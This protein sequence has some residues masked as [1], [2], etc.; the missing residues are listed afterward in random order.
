VAERSKYQQKI[1]K[2]YYNNVEAISL[3][4]A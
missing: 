2:N 3:H 4:S 1:I